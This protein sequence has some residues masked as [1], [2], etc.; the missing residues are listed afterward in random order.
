MLFLTAAAQAAGLIALRSRPRPSTPRQPRPEGT[1]QFALDRERVAAALIA[2]RTVSIVTGV[3]AAVG[4]V[5][6]RTGVS[7]EPVV[8]TA[9]LAILAA[10]V[11]EGIPR[12]V[13]TNNADRWTPAL[14]PLVTVLRWVF[15][16][17]GYLADLPGRALLCLPP[18][19]PSPQPEESDEELLR[20]VEREQSEG[21]I[22][23]DERE[24]IRAVIE[25]EDTTAREIMVP[26]IDI[27]AVDVGAT[28]AAVAA[29]IAEKGVSRVP[30]YEG[31]IDNIVG[32]IYA[33]DVLAHLARGGGEVDLRTIA[34]SAL[35]VPESK[36]VDELLTELRT[37]KIHIA[38][39]VDE[40]GGTA[41]LLT[42]EDLV[43]EIVGEI[44]DEYDHGE[45]SWV[46][47]GD[48]DAVVD[49]GANVYVLKE[50]FD[51]EVEEGDFDTVGGLIINRLGK[52]P[53]PNDTVNVDGLQLRVL[54]VTGRRIRKVR[55]TR[56]Q[57]SPVSPRAG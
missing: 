6:R 47:T 29:L 55:V 10:C 57:Q 33:K 2:A 8:L 30:L 13:V 50:L 46:R 20:L 16:V 52:I 28:V 48:G 26:R 43:E 56:L 51:V 9:L 19:R 54:S 39:V 22:E 1:A 49:A 17:P 34:R 24:M 32:V 40:Y 36:P 25:L 3:A 41:G 11:I 4:L 53:T 23:Q 31:T 38:I 7:A 45:P 27:I 44:E 35:F 21:G 15:F 14:S 12:V 18:L 42:I 37:Q 5:V